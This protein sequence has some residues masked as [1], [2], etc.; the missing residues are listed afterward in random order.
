MKFNGKLILNNF[1]YL[2]NKKVKNNKIY[3]LIVLKSELFIFI[4]LFF[5]FFVMIALSFF[6]I[7]NLL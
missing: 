4:N 6:R 5:K 1:I 2:L 7:Y 3:L